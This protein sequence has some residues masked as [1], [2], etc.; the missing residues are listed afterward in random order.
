MEA[1]SLASLAAKLDAL[2]Y[3]VPAEGLPAPAGP[4]VEQARASRGRCLRRAAL[5]RVASASARLARAIRE[6]S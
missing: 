2:D 3:A 1:P 4:L 5:R 6:R